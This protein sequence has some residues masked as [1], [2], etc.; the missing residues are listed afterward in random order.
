MVI[1]AL[2]FWWFS[3]VFI[4]DSKSRKEVYLAVGFGVILPSGVLC[5]PMAVWTI[6][7]PGWFW[8]VFSFWVYACAALALRFRKH[9]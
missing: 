3:R 9:R 4:D 7:I 8:L 2:V 6:V 1:T 5:I